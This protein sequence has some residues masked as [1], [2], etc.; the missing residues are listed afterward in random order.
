MDTHQ[1]KTTKHESDVNVKSVA[2]A[3]ATN[4]WSSPESES[5]KRDSKVKQKTSP[6]KPKKVVQLA[7]KEPLKPQSNEDNDVHESMVN[8]ATTTS[9]HKTLKRGLHCDA[10]YLRD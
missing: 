4:R 5:D 6:D 10:A 8:T 1:N 3:R 7:H 2:A 9:V